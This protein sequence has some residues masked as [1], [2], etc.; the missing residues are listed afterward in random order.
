MDFEYWITEYDVAANV[1]GQAF[2]SW[3]VEDDPAQSLSSG[4]T[5][6]PVEEDTASR[7]QLFL[8]MR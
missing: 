3:V 5:P 1:G 7:R 8:C 6:P 2:E 4:S